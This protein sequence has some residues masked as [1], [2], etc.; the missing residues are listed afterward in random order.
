[1]DSYEGTHKRAYVN[2]GLAGKILLPLGIS[3]SAVFLVL[4]AVFTTLFVVE[5]FRLTNPQSW[6]PLATVFV[7]LMSVSWLFFVIGLL[8][9]IPGIVFTILSKSFRRNDESRGIDYSEFDRK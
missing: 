4:T 9:L 8:C 5:V 1:M 2:F 3:L 6:T 7:I